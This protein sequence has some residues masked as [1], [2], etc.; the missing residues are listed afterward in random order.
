[1]LSLLDRL[2]L[3]G[4]T[5]TR[6]GERLFV[7]PQGRITDEQHAEIAAGKAQLL[8]DLEAEADLGLPLRPPDYAVPPQWR[9]AP[10]WTP[11]ER[12]EYDAMRRLMIEVLSGAEREAYLA[13][14]PSAEREAYLASRDETVWPGG[15]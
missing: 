2:R 5:V 15:R 4:L 3:D 11:E 6:D 9:P 8:A 14:L 1:M 12:A 10:P 7:A 13:L